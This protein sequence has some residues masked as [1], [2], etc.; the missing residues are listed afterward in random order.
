MGNLVTSENL[1]FGQANISFK[2]F[3]ELL[4]CGMSQE[5]FLKTFKDMAEASITPFD[6]IGWHI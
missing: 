2:N 3:Q 6:T 4:F 1:I 5:I